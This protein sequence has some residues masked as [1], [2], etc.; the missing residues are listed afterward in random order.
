MKLSYITDEA[1][2]D[3]DQA[4]RFAQEQGFSG[5]ELRSASDLP[6][7]S[8]PAEQLAQWK[9]LLDREGLQVPDIAGSFLKCDLGDPM[10]MAEEMQKLER[11]CQ[12]AQLFECPYVRGFAGFRPDS[13]CIAPRQLLP[14]FEKAEKVLDSY[15]IR[16]L[17]EADPSVNTTNH[18]ALAALL[19]LLPDRCFG[20]V[21]DPG[22]DLYDPERET[23]YPDGYDAVRP[24]LCHV[25]VKDVRYD[26]G[27]RPY[28]VAPGTGLVGWEQ[29]LS[30]LRSDGYGGWLS[31]ETHYRKDVVLTEALTRVPAG[32]DFSRGGM[33]ATAESMTALKKLIVQTG[34]T[35]S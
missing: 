30:R 27:G 29:I 5:L 31:V 28:C 12:A 17:L 2:Q 15:G 16:L 25:H 26:A 1:T 14:Y 35:P 23:P 24:Y 13:G 4:V 20:A 32:N 21:Y 33:E 7:D 34:G 22:N 9:K 6:V 19:Q 18:A 11:L 8:I 10:Q 3:F